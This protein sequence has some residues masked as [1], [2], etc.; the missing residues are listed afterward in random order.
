MLKSITK[1]INDRHVIRGTKQLYFWYKQCNGYNIMNTNIMDITLNCIKQT[2]KLLKEEQLFDIYKTVINKYRPKQ[3]L[4]V[5]P[6]HNNKNPIDNQQLYEKMS[7][8]NKE[9]E[10]EKEK[11]IYQN[12]NIYLPIDNRINLLRLINNPFHTNNYFVFNT[13][14]SKSYKKNHLLLNIGDIKHLK[15]LFNINVNRQSDPFIRLYI[16]CFTECP[17]EGKLNNNNIAHDLCE[18]QR[19]QCEKICLVDNMGTLELHDLNYI[20]TL[21]RHYGLK[22]EQLALQLYVKNGNNKRIEKI[23][24]YALDIGITDFDMMDREDIITRSSEIV[25][26]SYEL[27]NKII[28]NYLVDKS[29]II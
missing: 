14:F 11:E 10:K 22:V 13:S 9:K 25:P 19:L 18:M 28:T 20:I 5:D 2:D 24:Y 8:Y 3:I 29:N 12:I 1:S 15:T 21:G 17:Y 23:I 26:L 4:L 7:R 16:N 27:Y 6:L